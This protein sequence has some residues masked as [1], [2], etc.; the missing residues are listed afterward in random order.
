MSNQ[1][2]TRTCGFCF[3][4]FTYDE[5]PEG[6]IVYLGV[7]ACADCLKTEVTD[8][9]RSLLKEEKKAYKKRFDEQI[10]W[11]SIGK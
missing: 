6:T 9:F 7:C 8:E 2:K 1:T 5:I 3:K 10:L 4:K 11:E